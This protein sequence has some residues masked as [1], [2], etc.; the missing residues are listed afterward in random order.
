MMQGHLFSLFLGHVQDFISQGGYIVLFLS[1]VLEGIPL[2]GMVVPGHVT[3]MIGG[4]LAKLGS[5]NLSWVIIISIIGALLGDYIGFSIGKRYGM[6]F[7]EKLRPYLF[8][9]NAQIDK[10]RS[11]LSKHTGKSLIIGRFTPA[12]R[13]LMPFLVGTTSTPYSSFWIFNI[14]GGVLWVV[15]SIMIGYLFGS[16]YHI[17]AGYFG[18]FLIASIIAAIIFVWGYR[19]INERF[20]VFCRYELFTLI[21]NILTLWIFSVTLDRLFDNSFKLSFDVWVNL[22]MQKFV[23]AHA[24]LTYIAKILSDIGSGPIIIGVSIIIGLYFA[25]NRKWRSAIIPVLTLF[26]TSLSTSFLKNLFMSPRPDVA[27]NYIL[28]PGF[29]SGHSSFSAALFFV[30]IYLFAPKI[31]SMIKREVFIVLCIIA[32]IA[33]GISRLVLNVHWFTDVVGGWS[34]G[35]F[36]ATGVVLFIRYISVLLLKKNN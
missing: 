10:A 1:T 27:V 15:S 26:L 13:A 5:I 20:H 31:K 9:S 7:I 30:I 2:V 23:G 25:Y 11:L 17:V 33:V 8:I 24:Y 19:F 28:G 16:A 4:F 14:I 18:R 34:L 3:I 21:I 35:L 22:W 29:P 36:I 6:N 12:T 32:V